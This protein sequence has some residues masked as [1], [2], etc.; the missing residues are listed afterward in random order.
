MKKHNA[1][2]EAKQG[3]ESFTKFLTISSAASFVVIA[4]VVFVIS[5]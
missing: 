2:K 4:L 3:W 5:Y 1:L